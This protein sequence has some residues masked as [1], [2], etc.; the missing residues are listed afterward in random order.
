MFHQQNIYKVALN[1]LVP[2]KKLCKTLSVRWSVGLPVRPSE[3]TLCFRSFRPCF[4]RFPLTKNDDRVRGVGGADACRLHPDA[5]DNLRFFPQIYSVRIQTMP[6]SSSM[7][8]SK[9][10]RRVTFL[11]TP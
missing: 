7:V 4:V 6:N 3:I 1:V 9:T 5:V 11:K 2:K 8:A 10:P